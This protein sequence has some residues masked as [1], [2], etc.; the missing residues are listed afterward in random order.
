MPTT[1]LLNRTQSTWDWNAKTCKINKQ[2]GTITL[3]IT[4]IDKSTRH[5]LNLLPSNVLLITPVFVAQAAQCIDIKT[6]LTNFMFHS[7]YCVL[8]VKAADVIE[9]GKCSP[10]IISCHN[11]L[12]ITSTSPPLAITKLYSSYRSNTDLAIIGNRLMGVPIT[13]ML[14]LRNFIAI[15]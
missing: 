6:M 9:D 1:L 14:A 8:K 11:F 5:L 13:K 3:L 15:K 2:P 7:T 12:L 4:E 10:L